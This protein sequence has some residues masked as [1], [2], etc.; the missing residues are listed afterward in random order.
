MIAL[1]TRGLERRGMKRVRIA[2][3]VSDVEAALPS[4][5]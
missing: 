3:G 1:P 2:L 5:T 4:V